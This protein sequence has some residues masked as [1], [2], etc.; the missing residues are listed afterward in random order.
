MAQ[1]LNRLLTT[2]RIRY[3]ILRPFWGH[4]SWFGWSVIS[5]GTIDAACHWRGSVYLIQ[6]TYSIDFDTNREHTLRNKKIRKEKK[7]RVYPC[8][9]E[10]FTCCLIDGLGVVISF[11][12]AFSQ[13]E[14]SN[15]NQN[16]QNILAFLCIFY[17]KTIKKKL[18]ANYGKKGILI[19]LIILIEA[20]VK[21]IIFVDICQFFS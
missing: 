19:I 14:A 15:Y 9:C 18:T 13:P 4:F 1:T 6:W 17:G 5:D 2:L 20:I 12:A 7:W 3:L 16:K 11:L 10:E 21:V 8:G